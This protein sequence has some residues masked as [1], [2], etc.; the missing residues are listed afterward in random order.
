MYTYILHIYIYTYMYIYTQNWALV[1]ITSVPWWASKRDL[2]S[3]SKETWYQCQKRP[4]EL[5]VHWPCSNFVFEIFVFTSPHA[6]ITDTCG[7]SRF[8]PFFV[9]EI[10]VF[11]SCLHN[12]YLWVFPLFPW[13]NV[14]LHTCPVAPLLVECVLYGRGSLLSLVPR[15]PTHMPL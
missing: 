1:Y 5:P 7:F 14:F 12:G 11:T 8:F 3:V 2:V 9:F 13:S 4:D 6:F 15:I 10:F